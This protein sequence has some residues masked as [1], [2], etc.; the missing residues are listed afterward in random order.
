MFMLFRIMFW[1]GVLRYVFLLVSAYYR[2]R[3][4]KEISVDLDWENEYFETGYQNFGSFVQTQVYMYWPVGIALIAG[5]IYTQ[6]GWSALLFLPVVSIAWIILVS[7]P[8]IIRSN[9]KQYQIEFVSSWAEKHGYYCKPFDQVNRADFSLRRDGY[10][11]TV[12]FD[13][14]KPHENDVWF[15]VYGKEPYTKFDE[16]KGCL[17]SSNGWTDSPPSIMLDRIHDKFS[18]II[19]QFKSDLDDPFLDLKSRVLKNSEAIQVDF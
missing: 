10:V 16:I 4:H 15:F 13:N 3:P 14:D 12:F 17:W 9:R 1:I 18:P 6:S 8:R 2:N 5:V 11:L 19:P 7:M